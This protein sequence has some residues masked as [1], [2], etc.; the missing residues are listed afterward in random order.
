MAIYQ[1]THQNSSLD[2][3]ISC[4]NNQG[5]L[6]KQN[7]QSL[8]KLILEGTKSNYEN[9][10]EFRKN[11]TYVGRFDKNLTPLEIHYVPPKP[12]EIDSFMN[13]FFEFISEIY[14]NNI[15]LN[16]FI[17][18]AFI[19]LLQPFQDGNTR[20]ARIIQ[21][22]IIWNQTNSIFDLSL[23]S[24]ALYFSENYLHYG[25]SKYRAELKQ[26]A[27]IFDSDSWERWFRYNMTMVEEQLFFVQNNLKEFKKSLKKQYY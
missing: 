19:A 26:L 10:Q 1:Q 8:H 22:G 20:L 17:A 14:T 15:F 4:Y 27:Q 24:P 11:D 9:S 5:F 7:I 18:H 23:K 13:L 25:K 12:D 21:Y 16:A 3:L 2:F 6:T